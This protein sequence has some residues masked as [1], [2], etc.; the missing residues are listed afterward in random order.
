[1]ELSWLNQLTRTLHPLRGSHAPLYRAREGKGLRLRAS[2]LALACILFVPLMSSCGQMSLTDEEHYQRA[3]EFQQQ[4][5][6]QTALIEFKNA[7]QKNPAH[8]EARLG[9]GTVS[10]EIGDVATAR[11]ELERAANLGVDRRAVLRPLA[12]IWL[13]EGEYDRIL[14]QVEPGDFEAGTEA[15]EALVLRAGALVGLGYPAQ[16]M[17]TLEEAR[18]QAPDLALVDMGIAGVHRSQGQIADARASLEAALEKDPGFHQAW[19]FLGELEL[20][21]GRPSEAE[22][23][24]GQAIDLAP[25]APGLHFQRA[26]T[27]FVLQDDAGMQEDVAALRRLVPG[28]P[29]TTYTLGLLLYLQERYA[30]AQT[31]FE[32]VLARQPALDS[33]AFFLGATHLAQGRWRQAE[34]HLSRFLNAHPESDTAARMLAQARLGYGDPDAA[35]SA[36]RTL[37][38]RN[39][40]D[41]S[42]LRSLANIQLSQG[43]TEAA[44]GHLREL[45]T[46][47]PDDPAARATLAR[48]LLETGQREEGLRELQAI[49]EMAP[50]RPDLEEFYVYQL[51][52]AGEADAA[53]E[54]GARLL[55][56]HPENTVSYNL[57]AAAYMLRNDLDA[58]REILER[59]LLVA[60]G[61]PDI[62]QN[63]AQVWM[64]SGS[65]MEA[66]R[67]LR[68]SLQQN[69]GHVELALRLAQME[70]ERPD[71]EAA[72]VVLEESIQHHPGALEPRLLLAR[73]HM[74][75]DDPQRAVA[76]LEPVR[77]S[78]ASDPRMLGLLGEAQVAA[79]KKSQAVTTFRALG[80]QM[81][82]TPENRHR[83]GVRFEQADSPDD[84]AI[85]YRRAL[86]LDPAHPGTL[87]SWAVLEMRE[88]RLE[89]ALALARRLQQHPGSVAAGG[90]VIEGAIHAR[91]QRNASAADAFSQAYE[92]HPSVSNALALAEAHVLIGQSE[93]AAEVL[94]GHLA[95]H[96][97]DHAV[98]TRLADIL[99][100]M[101]RL[102]QA[103][104]Q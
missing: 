41:V 58:A 102:E 57:T 49:I 23:A 88:G 100:D 4:G 19:G 14:E 26:I 24:F 52:Q 68:E 92:L 95:S 38:G 101:E 89:E 37:L 36:L 7:L 85:Q 45:A 25:T 90:F 6:R 22:S 65:P 34:Q 32:Q 30:D 56:R 17:A 47:R 16:A 8:A 43:Q 2:G 35:S 28:S 42:T 87:R 44:I 94:A 82:D 11:A 97:D 77:D 103:N 31:A 84:A 93:Q 29:A 96:P 53:I 3:L 66:H 50:G 62:S 51:V 12:R 64:R 91:A 9:L 1:M 10:L 99:L 21:A 98:R 81:Q 5:D 61:A 13:L 104:D 39:P 20:A 83:L 63:L 15:A 48:T 40:E 75:R 71:F 46:I 69:P 67:V 80:E 27:R 78:S 60:P 76:V 74:V 54:A 33:A 79:G 18:R 55:D 86:E 73:Q 70:L 72:R 59:G